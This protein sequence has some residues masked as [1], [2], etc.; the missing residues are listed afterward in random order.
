MTFLKLFHKYKGV[1]FTSLPYETSIVQNKTIQRL[2]N[3]K[4]RV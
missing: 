1:D 4:I 2:I 3:N